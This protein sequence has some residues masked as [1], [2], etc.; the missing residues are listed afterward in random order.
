MVKKVKL[1]SMYKMA[2]V[3]LFGGKGWIGNQLYTLFQSVAEVQCSELRAHDQASVDKEIQEKRPTHV[4]SCIGR[5]HG[6]IDGRKIQTID[7]LEEPG[8]L[9]ENLT[10]NLYAPMVLA[11]VCQQYGIHFTYLGTGCIFEYDEQHSIEHPE[12]G[13]TE[14]DRPNFF[15]SSYSTVKG[16]TD[17]LMTF[18]PTALNVRIRMP[19]TAEINDRD[20]ITKIVGYQKICSVPNSMTVLDELLPIMVDMVLKNTTGT[21]QLVNPGVISHEEVLEM[22]R[23]L[24]DPT[25]TWETMTYEQQNQLL[26]S[27]RSNNSLD[28]TRLQTLYPYVSDIHTAVRRA[29]TSRGMH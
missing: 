16:I 18:F 14:S 23:E 4:V 2:R 11:N 28:T 5:T 12:K 7:Y 26:K 15:G 6:S 9:L 25:K 3:L 19:I 20:F 17:Q 1:F 22:Y 27:K 13:F 8:K 21:I 29:L 10:D 24:C